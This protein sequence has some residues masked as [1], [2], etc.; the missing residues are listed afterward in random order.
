MTNFTGKLRILAGVLLLLVI[1][2]IGW[3]GHAR[4]DA[5]VTIW[6]SQDGRGTTCSRASPCSLTTAQARAD[7]LAPTIGGDV[8]VYLLAGLYR[9]SQPLTFTAQDSGVNGHNIIYA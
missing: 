1:T 2:L 5:G 3:A 7:V 6:A 8:T 9:L 4:V